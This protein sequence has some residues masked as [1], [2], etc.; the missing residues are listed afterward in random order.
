MPSKI[1]A[2]GAEA[3]F[4]CGVIGTAEAVPFPTEHL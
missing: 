2:S 4:F 3:R 1:F